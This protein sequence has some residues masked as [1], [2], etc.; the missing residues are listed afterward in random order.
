[1]LIASPTGSTSVKLSDYELS[2]IISALACVSSKP[3]ML[4]EEVKER[5]PKDDFMALGGKLMFGLTPVYK[6]VDAF[7]EK[8]AKKM[9]EAHEKDLSE[10]DS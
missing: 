4:D 5:C 8:L 7:N 10:E 3:E 6:G 2:L 9:K 1:M